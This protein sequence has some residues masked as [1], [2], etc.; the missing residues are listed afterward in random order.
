MKESLKERIAGFFQQT[1]RKN[2]L[3]YAFGAFF[4]KGLSFFLLPLYTNLLTP[5][6][7][8]NYELLR[9]FGSIIEIVFSLGLLQIIYAEFFETHKDSKTKL[10]S[11]FLSVYLVI[12]TSL[13]ILLAVVMA[14]AGFIIL[15]G[16]KFA[17][18]ALVMAT[19][20]LNFFQVLLITILKLSYQAVRVSVLQV[21]LGITNMALNIF[22]VFGLRIGIDGILSSSFVITVL[23]C[24]YGTWYFRKQLMNFRISFSWKEAKSYM[25]ISLPFIPNVLSF[26]LM[27]SANRWILLNYSGIHEVGIYSAAAR[28]TAVFEPLLMDPFM[29]VYLPVVFS[30]FRDGKY[31]QSFFWRIAIIPTV[32]VFFGL[33]MKWVGG[34]VVGPDFL[35][36]LVLVVPLALSYSFNLIAQSSGLIM[37]YKK[38]VHRMLFCVI[39]GSVVSIGMNFILVPEYG[40]MGSAIGTIAG[41]GVWAILV[42]SN[43]LFILRNQNKASI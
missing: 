8:G 36:S 7:L 33:G 13:Y 29:S 27:N 26:W 39:T 14:F 37:V 23:S 30:N 10:L 24:A 19:T 2:F 31:K 22:L 5:A 9:N 21:V 4:L 42:I 15:P 28:F 18:I 20:Y 40:A 34:M 12:S 1:H 35:D 6:E 41:N 25:A 32:F 11:S 17:L 43:A 16:I 3:I 38:M